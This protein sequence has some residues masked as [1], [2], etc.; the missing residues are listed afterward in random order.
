L[1]PAAGHRGLLG[2]CKTHINYYFL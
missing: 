1:S 2:H